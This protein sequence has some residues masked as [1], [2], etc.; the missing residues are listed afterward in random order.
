MRVC[1]CVCVCV[2][3]H[4]KRRERPTGVPRGNRLSFYSTTKL[5]CNSVC[6]IVCVCVHA[7]TYVTIV[8]LI[9]FDRVNRERRVRD[10]FFDCV[11]SLCVCVCVC[12]SLCLSVRV[13]TDRRW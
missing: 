2:C 12:V 10:V 6:V 9:F 5:Q 11:L 8:V 4:E 7:H 1:V 13:R 3:A